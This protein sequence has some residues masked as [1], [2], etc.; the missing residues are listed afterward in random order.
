[1][2][3]WALISSIILT[4]NLTSV[5]VQHLSTIELIQE[6]ERSLAV[7]HD[8]TYPSGNLPYKKNNNSLGVN[9]TAQAAAV[10]DKD[11]GAI[12]WQKNADQVRSLA[13]ITKLMTALVFLE[14]NPG[15]DTQVTLE[16]RDEA[17]SNAPNILRGETVT[18]K[19]LFYTSLIASD[20][21][22]AN[23]LVRSTGMDRDE[24]VDLMNQK[25]RNLKLD[26]TKF[27]DPTGLNQDNVSTALEILKLADTAF[28]NQDIVEV[29]AL[30]EYNFQAI[31]G[32]HHRV[33]ST[34]NLLSS[35]LDVVA[36]KTGFIF[37][38]GYCLV[39]E[40]KSDNGDNIIG[41][42]LGS[43]TNLDRFQDL[44]ILS[45]WIIDNFVWS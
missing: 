10:M 40:I 27:K 21:N 35:Y 5:P 22:T 12:L 23:A 19:D 9:I 11:S 43:S 20:N 42:V 36:G 38:S 30:K 24:F 6:D 17:N 4:F 39:S 41:V 14:N 33:F 32:K 37:E 7:L 29:T 2:N 45:S 16:K 25:A 1:M 44:K 28:A 26:N 34:N 18:I 8:K 31:T 15:W 3:L 13:S